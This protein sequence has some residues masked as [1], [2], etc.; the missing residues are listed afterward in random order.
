VAVQ[1]GDG[2]AGQHSSAGRGLRRGLQGNGVHELNNERRGRVAH[3]QARVL[4]DFTTTGRRQR[5]GNSGGGEK[6][7]FRRRRKTAGGSNGLGRRP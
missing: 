6:L 4:D 2:A 5:R 1:R 3:L 7:G